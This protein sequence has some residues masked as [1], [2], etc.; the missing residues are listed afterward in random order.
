MLVLSVLAGLAVSWAYL[1][2]RPP[3]YEATVKIMVTPF[4]PVGRV[5]GKQHGLNSWDGAF[6]RSEYAA[7]SRSELLR[8]IFTSRRFLREALSQGEEKEVRL[9]DEEIER[10]Q[11]N[12]RFPSGDYDEDANSFLLSLVYTGQRPGEP[13]DVL[14]ALVAH[15]ADFTVARYRS[16]LRWA[17]KILR[18]LL[19]DPSFT[20]RKQNELL[21]ELETIQ[22]AQLVTR[23]VGREYS[24]DLIN[25]SGPRRVSQ[26]RVPIVLAGGLVG[27]I[28]G[29]FSSWAVRR[30]VPVLQD[31]DDVLSLTD[32]DLLGTL[33]N[34]DE[35]TVGSI[36]RLTEAPESTFAESIRNTA[37]RLR[38]SR[39]HASARSF[40]VTSPGPG[41]GKTTAAVNLS[42]TL[43]DHGHKTLLVDAD[44]R[45]GK[46]HDLLNLGR[47]P[48]L[49]SLLEGSASPEDVL[50]RDDGLHVVPVGEPAG[51][52]VERLASDRYEEVMAEYA[53]RYDYVVLDGTSVHGRADIL[54]TSR[55][56]DGIVL[57]ARAD[58]TD[59]PA[60]RET[61]RQL[62]AAI[63][64]VR[65]I[66]L[67][68]LPIERGYFTSDPPHSASRR[69]ASAP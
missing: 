53:R 65:G 1:A 16:N 20:D 24:V 48:G 7:R 54:E 13:I 40:V 29:L 69:T 32:V 41:D 62:R 25:A 23:E 50:Q 6:I 58:R 63:P 15:F 12:L 36:P 5:L 8:N 45:S 3:R 11:S 37:A 60:L 57:V 17:E 42:R 19:D 38:L 55:C 21:R 34:V 52:V 14:R 27:L 9:S 10:I 43:A 68:D 44:L 51:N 28:F 30:L 4:N 26:S 66:V 49:T 39:N 2:H 33:P 56:L 64:P 46:I 67:N 59:R 35:I 47:T 31:P 18:R 22:E 61:L